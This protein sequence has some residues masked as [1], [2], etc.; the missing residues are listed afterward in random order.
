MWSLGLL[1]KRYKACQVQIFFSFGFSEI[2]RE[3]RKVCRKSQDRPSV[4]NKPLDATWAACKLEEAESQAISW[5]E[6][7]RLS[8]LMEIW[9]W[10][11]L[12]LHAGSVWG[13]INIG[14]MDSASTSVQKK[15]A[16]TAL[17][18]KFDHLFFSPYVSG[19]PQ[20]AAPELELKSSESIS[21][22]I[23]VQAF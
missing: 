5:V 11:Q 15:A 23:Q 6:Q 7:P 17:A 16:P 14:T 19:A 9:I 2:L 1:S 21:K 4:G 13:G 22:L 18:L 12:H 20:A 8:I 3:F 10:R